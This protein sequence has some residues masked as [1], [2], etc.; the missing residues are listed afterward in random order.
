MIDKKKNATL[1]DKYYYY[2]MI[3]LYNLIHT[4][5]CKWKFHTVN[6]KIFLN[7]TNL[8][9]DD[10]SRNPYLDEYCN[11]KIGLAEDILQN[12]MYFP[13]FVYGLPQEQIDQNTISIALGKHRFYSK[14]LYQKKYGKIDKKFLFIYVP[15][16][17]PQIPYTVINNYFYIFKNN[18][19]IFSD[20]IFKHSRQE[21]MKYFDLTGGHLSTF[22]VKEKIPTHPILNDEELFKQ[23]IESPL[24]EKN[25]LFQYYNQYKLNKIDNKEDL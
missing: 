16:V 20:L 6:E 15:N 19:L 1:Q 12:G 25:I 10:F 9:Y 14:L 22:L 2:Y 18:Q 5:N 21:L 8:K 24:D 23:F 7:G 3:S 13:Y 4:Y 11:N 17:L